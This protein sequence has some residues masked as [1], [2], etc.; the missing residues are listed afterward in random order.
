[1][2]FF[3]AHFGYIVLHEKSSINGLFLQMT[4]NLQKNHTCSAFE[5]KTKHWKIN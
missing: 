5:I 1:M 2:Y 3:L 4:K